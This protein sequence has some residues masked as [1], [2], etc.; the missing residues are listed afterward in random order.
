MVRV[1]VAFVGWIIGSVRFGLRMLKSLIVGLVRSPITLIQNS[2][3][4]YFEAGGMPWV[5]FLILLLWS[6]VE[7]TIFTFTL[8]PTLKEVFDSLTGTEVDP[9]IMRPLL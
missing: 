9:R 7:A 4:A 1:L 6:A 2:S 3:R 8:T 5:A